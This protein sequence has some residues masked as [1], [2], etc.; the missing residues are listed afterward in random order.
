MDRPLVSVV[1]TVELVGPCELGPDDTTYPYVVIRDQSNE[2]HHFGK[3]SAEPGVSQLV[4]CEVSGLFVFWGNADKSRL[5][6]VVCDD[7]R[8]AVDFASLRKGQR[9]RS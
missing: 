1:G 9:A 7:G 6:C 2:A 4:E 5:W 8:Q 3:V